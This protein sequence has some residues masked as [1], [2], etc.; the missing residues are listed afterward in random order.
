MLS[1]KSSVRPSAVQAKS[2]WERGC[3]Q[4]RSDHQQGVL[5][6][7]ISRSLSELQDLVLLDLYRAALEDIPPELASNHCLVLLGGSGRREIAPFSDVDIMLLYQGTQSEGLSQFSQRLFQDITDAGFDLGFSLRTVREACSMSLEDAYIYSSL[8][9]ARF[10]TGNQ[11]LFENFTGRFQRIAGRRTLEV[12][13]AIVAAREKERNDFGETVYLLRPNIKRSRGGLRDIHLIR[14]L[15]FVQFGQT[16]IDQLL[17]AGAISTAD[18]T[19]L[20]LS[21]EFLLRVRNE[22]H[23]NAQAAE[24]LLGRNEQLRLANFFG[25]Q[26]SSAVLAVENFMRDYFRFTSRVRY[27]CDHFVNKATT[28][29][30]GVVWATIEHFG[31]RQIDDTFWIGMNQIGV[32]AGAIERVQTDLEQV[33][34]LMQLC[35]LHQK[36]I[37]HSAWIAIRHTM[38]KFPDIAVTADTGRR[39]MALLSNTVGLPESLYRLHEMQVLSKIIPAFDHARGLLQFNEY[40]RY[41]VDEHTLRTIQRVVEFAQLDSVLGKT[42][43]AIRDKNVLHLAL[44][45]HD[46]GKGYE[47]DH[48]DVGAEIAERTGLRLALPEETIED[49]KYLVQHHLVMSHL[50]FHR[51][52]NDPALVA[53]FASNIGSVHL[54]SMLY[55]LTCADIAAV[56]PDSLNPWKLG[57]LTDLYLHAKLILLGH[58]EDAVGDRFRRIHESVAGCGESPEIQ[59]WLREKSKSLPVSYSLHRAYEQIAQDL[60]EMKSLQPGE[61]WCRVRKLEQSNLYEL[62]VTKFAHRRSGIFYRLSGLLSSLGLEIRTAD[63]KP[64]A[65]GLIFYWIQFEDQEFNQTHPERIQEIE[66]RARRI[67]LG[68]DESPPKFRKL[69]KRDETQEGELPRTRIEVKINNLTADSATIIDVFAYNKTGLLCIIVKKIYALGLDI[70]FSRVATYAHRVVGVFY[71]TDALGNKIR[72][73]NQLQIIRQEI[74]KA[75]ADFLTKNGS[76]A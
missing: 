74:L 40:H 42:Y 14:W 65:E 39:F 30:P 58:S 43:N 20:A 3:Q 66:Q 6:T 7:R 10:L 48:S 57:L 19:Q 16:E 23:F 50:A 24:D 72:N 68:L 62:C 44:L 41:T 12:I 31:S 11:E 15:G 29:R 9:E 35:C 54:L 28:R 25:Y 17:Q 60:L 37:E 8:T 38:L 61:A 13:K 5:G 52:I 67:A 33:L 2:K 76:G 69:W 53:E 55:V 63:I 73:R 34:R 27:I 26:Q 1:G 36:K 18:S 32:S 4:I 21:L 59:G 22:M 71:V 45:M 70:T 47:G 64:L 49:V 46:L 51:D 75:V 56:G